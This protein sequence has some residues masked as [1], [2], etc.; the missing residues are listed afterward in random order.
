M[1]IQGSRN[2]TGQVYF[3][4]E[5]CYGW[6]TECPEHICLEMNGPLECVLRPLY[7][8]RYVIAVLCLKGNLYIF[9]LD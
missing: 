4:L 3:W 2:I 8:Y 7:L 1:Q 6:Y 9:V 5:I